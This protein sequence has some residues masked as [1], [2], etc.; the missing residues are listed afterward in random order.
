MPKAD[1]ISDYF[2]GTA[3]LFFKKYKILVSI[4]RDTGKINESA[5]PQLLC[6]F[7][8]YENNIDVVVAINA[9]ERWY[10]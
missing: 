8:G 3:S 2:F 7:Y 10:C 4:A 5:Q 9:L 1:R 6:T